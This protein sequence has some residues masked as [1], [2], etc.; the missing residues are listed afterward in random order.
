M[1]PLRAPKWVAALGLDQPEIVVEAFRRA[2]RGAPIP[3]AEIAEELAVTQPTVS[4][5]AKGDRTPSLE[6]MTEAIAVIERRLSQAQREAARA[7]EALNLTDEVM[8][9]GELYRD[10]KDATFRQR[11][12]A[13]MEKLDALGDDGKHTEGSTGNDQS[14]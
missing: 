7:R 12:L 10:T 11:M 1:S 4:R 8:E 14:P 13:V 2:L 6:Q 5:W 3:H 9:L